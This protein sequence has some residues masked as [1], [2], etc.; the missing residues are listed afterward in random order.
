MK[1]GGG[2]WSWEC[3]G[4]NYESSNNMVNEETMNYGKTLITYNNTLQNITY[5]K[6]K[7]NDVVALYNQKND[8]YKAV[9]KTE[10]C[11]YE[12]RLKYAEGTFFKTTSNPEVS[13]NNKMV[14]YKHSIIEK[15][16]LKKLILRNIASRVYKNNI[17]LI[18]KFEG[19]MPKSSTD[20]TK[21]HNTLTNELTA[22][23]LNKR[24]VDY[25]IEKNKANQNLL[26]L[27]GVLNVVAIGII[28]GIASS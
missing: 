20:L 17:A 21:Q 15:L 23:K 4:L 6:Q 9:M 13:P 28:Y 25:T 14:N 27:F 10:Y 22:S 16:K 7:Y 26:T 18:E 24:M 5:T 19:N 2:S 11:F 8:D 1:K 3:R 12:N